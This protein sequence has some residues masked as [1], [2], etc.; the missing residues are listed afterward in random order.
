MKTMT[1]RWLAVAAMIGSAI[2]FTAPAQALIR[3]SHS[4]GHCLDAQGGNVAP[5]VK[6]TLWSC[7]NRGNQQLW[8]D[9]GNNA[10][11]TGDDG[12]GYRNAT[13]RFND[14]THCLNA[15][16]MVVSTLASGDCDP[17][18]TRNVGLN[19]YTLQ[20]ID[21]R[22]GQ[23]QYGQHAVCLQPESLDIARH[24]NGMQMRWARCLYISYLEA[25]GGPR[26]ESLKEHILNFWSVEQ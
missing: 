18:R 12:H 13:I 14:G 1:R 10:S 6:V 22:V 8:L 16:R 19:R 3:T 26:L 7:H 25:P 5:G 20:R 15:E 11:Y 4:V 21:N 24:G 2:A 23:A 9:F 17:I